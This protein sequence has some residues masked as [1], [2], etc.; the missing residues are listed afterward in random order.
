MNA[1]W[2][3]LCT[4][5]L[6]A[7]GAAR[8]DEFKPMRLYY[9]RHVETVANATKVYNSENINV[10]SGKGKE[11][12]VALTKTLAALPRFDVIAVSPIPRAINSAVPYLKETSAVAELWPA[13]VECCSENERKRTEPAKD[14][15]LGKPVTIEPE[16]APLFDISRPENKRFF[17]AESLAQ[18]ILQLKQLEKQIRPRFGGTGKRV[19]LVGHSILGSMLVELLTGKGIK[20]GHRLENAKVSVLEEGQ[21]GVFRLVE[22]NGK[23]FKE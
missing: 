16:L 15:P 22:L 19:L 11:Q 1:V 17:V 6:V 12:V 7:A 23:P 4:A 10:F 14:L 21:D 18:G 8:A 13:L 2:I 20:I 9:A 3:G 5:A